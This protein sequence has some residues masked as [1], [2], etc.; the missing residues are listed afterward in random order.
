MLRQNEIIIDLGAIRHNY[1]L[2]RTQVPQG[3]R[4]MAVVKANAYGH[5]MVEVA[6]M[7]AAD[8]C[9]DF[10]V[11]IPE[12]GVT[13]REQ[14]IKANILVLGAATELAAET[15]VREQLTQTVFEPSMVQLLD[16]TAASLGKP[17]L[18]HIK[19]DTGMGRI[20][21]R[22]EGEADELASA[23]ANSKNVK[24]TGIYTHFADADHLDAQG[25]LNTYTQ[26]QLELFNLLRSHFDPSIPAHASNSAMS[27]V[28]PQAYFAMIREGISLYGYPPV[29]TG[30]D[31]QPALRWVSEVV[32]VKDIHAGDSVG[33]GC[34]YTADRDRRIA[35]VA[36]GYGD[37]YHRIVSN[38][39]QML[40]NGK[41]ANIVGRVCMDQT[42]LDVT[43]IPDVQTGSQVV[44][45]GMQGSE[46][47]GADELARWADTISYEVLL[48]IT[49]RVAR[50][51]LP[52]AQA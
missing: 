21:L 43:D 26:K 49:T 29:P 22:T 13:L 8:G 51:Y 48:A 14:G 24:V 32:Y 47:I 31:F 44:L 12:E 52:A 30:L 17:A 28:A 38:R 35:T 10:A 3:V 40:V 41:R 46:Y 16:E 27:L 50:S 37:G 34:T 19:L 36:V 15:A 33:Y 45:I 4:V 7:L 2:M 20:G 23:L 5:G 9:N 6:K 18:V 1:R 39:G 25:S 11:A 42:M